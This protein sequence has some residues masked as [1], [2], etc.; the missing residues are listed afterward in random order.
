M[1][2]IPANIKSTNIALRII[3]QHRRTLKY[4]P[5]KNH[6]LNSQQKA[7][8]FFPVRNILLFFVVCLG[9]VCWLFLFA[10]L[11]SSRRHIPELNGMAQGFPVSPLT[12]VHKHQGR[13]LTTPF[14]K[15]AADSYQNLKDTDQNKKHRSNTKL[16]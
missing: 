16:G 8:F 1:Y 7:L 3:V 9:L 13:M 6:Q 4:T 10:H 15:F 11:N 14:P 12:L 2:R 5:R